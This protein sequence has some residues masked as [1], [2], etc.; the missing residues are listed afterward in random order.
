MPGRGFA[1][2]DPSR[3]ARRN[4]DPQPW[5]KIATAKVDQ[6][7]LP[8]G[9]PWH[10]ETVKWW[11]M[12]GKSPL[13]ATFTAEDWSFLS[14][15]ALVHSALWSGDLKAAAELRLRVAKFGATPEDRQRLR[16]QFAAPSEVD[17]PEQGRPAGS[18]RERYAHLSVV[19][20][21]VAGP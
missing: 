19:N 15:T 6:P 13:S 18:S 10:P 7:A 3:R 11:A 2:K 21:A 17:E 9:V 8:D 20:D 16:I 14:E 12:W 1:P 5:Q 4:K